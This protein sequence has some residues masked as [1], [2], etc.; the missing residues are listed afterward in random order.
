MSQTYAASKGHIA[1][2]LFP[3]EKRITK[4][5]QMTTENT[6]WFYG[7]TINTYLGFSLCEKCLLHI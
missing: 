3:L 7:L 2:I 1:C 4:S 6:L 5:S